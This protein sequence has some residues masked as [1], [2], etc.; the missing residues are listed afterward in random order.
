MTQLGKEVVIHCRNRTSH[1]LTVIIQLE[2][3]D[4]VSF[5]LLYIMW[6]G[7]YSATD[8]HT[9]RYTQETMKDIAYICRSGYFRVCSCTV[10]SCKV[11][12]PLRDSRSSSPIV[13]IT[14]FPQ[15]SSRAGND[16]LSSFK[17][18]PL[19]STI[20]FTFIFHDCGC[21]AF[22]WNTFLKPQRDG[23]K[24][25]SHSSSISLFPLL[26][27]ATFLQQRSDLI[28]PLLNVKYSDF[29]V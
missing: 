10:C 27:E 5:P 25:D 12:S 9:H 19:L 13:H 4:Y 22:V 16:R 24:T 1:Q 29:L 17:S 11:C 15:D 21:T 6:D 18:T 7:A 8:I 23:S 28:L 2:S 26:L 14:V 3:S 20:M